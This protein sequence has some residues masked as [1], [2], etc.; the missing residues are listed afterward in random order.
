M[1]YKNKEEKAAYDKEYYQNNKEK[2]AKASKKYRAN[3]KEK[4][5]ERKKEYRAN[6]K[7]KIAAYS[8]EYRA[9][10]KEKGAKAS[11]EYHKTPIG[12]KSNRIS[13]WKRQGIIDADLG[14]VYDYYI[15]QTY[16]MICK[17]EFK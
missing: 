15:K 8:K 4:V 3:N 10:N 1:P 7:E 5:S 12:I 13:D 17:K 9:N 2:G 11:K 16:C 6:N 14:A